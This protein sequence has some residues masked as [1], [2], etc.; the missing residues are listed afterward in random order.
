[1]SEAIARGAQ[2][3]ASVRQR[4][5]FPAYSSALRRREAAWG[6][7]FA[8]PWLV[9]LLIFVLGPMLVS[10]YLSFS[11]YDI[12]NPPQ[13]IGIANYVRAF[14]ND[15]QFWPSLGRTFHYALVV[16]PLA[17][18]GHWRWQCCSTARSGVRPYF[19]PFTFCRT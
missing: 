17:Q 1:M 7:L 6:I 19:V 10:F 8:L 15:D 2:H 9:G 13:W 16:V 5:F 11:K 3:G 12:V 14:T 4:I 18:R